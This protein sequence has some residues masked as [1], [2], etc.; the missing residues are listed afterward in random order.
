MASTTPTLTGASHES[1]DFS[2]QNGTSRQMHVDEN[3][4]KDAVLRHIRTSSAVSISP[5]LFEKFYLSPQNKVSGDLRK[6]FSNPTPLYVCPV[7]LALPK[8]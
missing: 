1:K 7:I 6:T 4:S 2:D 5:E 3:T 8:A